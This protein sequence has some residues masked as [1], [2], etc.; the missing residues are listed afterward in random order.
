MSYRICMIVC[1]VGGHP[2]INRQPQEVI[3]VPG[4]DFREIWFRSHKLL[5]TSLTHHCNQWPRLRDEPGQ[6]VCVVAQGLCPDLS[7]APVSFTNI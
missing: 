3:E 6:K 7:I 1:V 2:H 5:H 4:Q